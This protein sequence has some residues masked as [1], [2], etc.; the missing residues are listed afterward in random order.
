[1]VSKKFI[2]KVCAV[3]LAIG[4]SPSAFAGGDDVLLSAPCSQ[5]LLELCRQGFLIA[6]VREM[7]S[8]DTAIGYLCKT[9]AEVAVFC[10][11]LVAYSSVDDAKKAHIERE[12]IR[13]CQENEEFRKAAEDCWVKTAGGKPLH[14]SSPVARPRK[15]IASYL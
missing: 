4:M 3:S 2:A 14:A 11:M 12:F 5:E 13:L 10:S 7:F 8:H 9:C 15:A 1:M 6:G